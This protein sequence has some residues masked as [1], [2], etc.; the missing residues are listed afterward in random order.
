MKKQDRLIRLIQS[1]TPLEKKYFQEFTARKNNEDTLYM[2]LFDL[3]SKEKIVDDNALKKQLPKS[4]SNFH[5]SKAYLYDLLLD[6]LSNLQRNDDEK[7]KRIQSYTHQTVLMNKGLYED[8]ISL[9]ND[10]ANKALLKLD[11]EAFLFFTYNNVIANQNLLQYDEAISLNNNYLEA[12]ERLK[13]LNEYKS[14]DLHYWKLKNAQKQIIENNKME[15]ELK[16]FMKHPLLSNDKKALSKKAK[17]IYYEIWAD[18]YGRYKEKMNDAV[19]VIQKNIDIMESAEEA[20]YISPG[21]YLSALRNVSCML[22]YN[23]KKKESLIYIEKIKSFKAPSPRFNTYKV[24]YAFYMELYWCCEFREHT[25][26]KKLIEVYEI[27]KDKAGIDET[28]MHFNLNYN[29]LTVYLCKFQFYD[30]AIH[31]LNL[32]V[33]NKTVEQN[34]SSYYANYKLMLIISY[35][36]IGNFK[37]LDSMIRTSKYYLEK[38]DLMNDADALLIQFFKKFLYNPLKEKELF[39][40]YLEAINLINDNSIHSNSL[41]MINDINWIDHMK[42]KLKIK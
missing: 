7:V 32:L 11:D 29:L 19:D 28:Q 27:D 2:K 25:K 16:K 31:F 38:N 13:N 12:L 34:F 20:N 37:V 35:H 4:A 1:L 8:S 39:I 10:E 33:N 21:K 22:T 5:K 6:S 36:M 17:V 15:I 14:L 42:K 26:A 23:L 18:Y 9:G 41:N 3:I 24:A 40:Q 30:Q